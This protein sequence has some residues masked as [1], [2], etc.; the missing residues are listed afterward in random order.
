M[1]ASTLHVPADPLARFCALHEALM[2]D[3][4]WWESGNLLRFAALALTPLS[5]EPRE[6]AAR[7]TTVAEDLREAQ[8]WHRRTSVGVLLAAQ[9]LRQGWSAAD[10]VAE[11]ERAAALF[12]SRWR[13]SGGTRESLAIL[14]LRQQAPG[15]RVGSE[16]VARLSAIWEEMRRAHPWLTQKTDWPACALLTA[17]PETPAQIGARLESLYQG[18]HAQGF[19]RG[20]ALQTAAQ[21]LVFHPDPAPLVCA[22]FAALY[23]AF[24][25]SGLWMGSGDYDEVA[26]LCY[27]DQPAAE[28]LETVRRHRERIAALAPKPDKQTSFSLSCGTALLQ[29]VRGSA[30]A[31]R[32]SETQA[33]LLVQAV[34]A[35]QA[36]AAVAAAT[37]AT[38]AT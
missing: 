30:D 18:L 19:Q 8:A 6:L 16:Q 28:V 9:I 11:L 27:A 14:V 2:A 10:T 38:A 5:G 36:A 37:A 21:V 7:L 26:L 29:L 13:L 12:R 31:R 1:H 22:R 25:A 20:D 3:R 35:A 17:L 4:S 24:H 32:L 23:R 33:I 15:G 34:L